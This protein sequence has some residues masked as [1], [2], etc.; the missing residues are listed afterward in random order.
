MLGHIMEWFYSDLSG[1]QCDPGDVAFKKI[2]I[3]PAIVGDITWASAS[4]NSPYGKINSSWKRDAAKLTL[5][6]TIPVGSTATV[7]LP[8]GDAAKITESGHPVDHA[9][10]VKLLRT[11]GGFTVFEI[12]SGRYRFEA[13][14]G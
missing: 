4:Y 13:Q 5:E 8:T 1:I 10:G 6:V 7:F 9:E 2:V 11:E 3:K 14:R 12:A